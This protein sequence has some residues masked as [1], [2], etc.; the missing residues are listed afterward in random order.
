MS[1]NRCRNFATIA[2]ED[3]MPADLFSRLDELHTKVLVSPIHNLDYDEN[4]V[5]KK[6]HYHILIMYSSVKSETQMRDIVSKLGTVG[7]E[8]VHSVQGYARYLTHMDNPEK[9]KYSADDVKCF[10]GADYSKLTTIKEEKQV[11]VVSDIL[12]FCKSPFF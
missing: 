7:C 5:M 12:L 6:A 4:G 11:N 9:T 10:G 2:Y 8:I 1:S 3:S